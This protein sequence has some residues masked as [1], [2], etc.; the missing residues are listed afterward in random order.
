MYTKCHKI[1]AQF[2]TVQRTLSI[3]ILVSYLW[4][5]Q[6]LGILLFRF[7]VNKS[8]STFA[9][10]MP[11][12]CVYIVYSSLPFYGDHPDRKSKEKAEQRETKSKGLSWKGASLSLNIN[13]N[14]PS[15][16]AF[17]SQFV[18]EFVKKLVLKNPRKL[19]TFADIS[20]W[21]CRY[22]DKWHVFYTE[23]LELLTLCTLKNNDE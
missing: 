17:F 15:S 13:V 1:F 20:H 19:F 16:T 6:V 21:S 9:E 4:L 14:D 10:N 8:Q 22:F 12:H 5:P 11:A 18:V 3:S 2:C 7:P 23:N